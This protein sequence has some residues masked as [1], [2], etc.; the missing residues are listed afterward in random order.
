LRCVYLGKKRLER[1]T[2][3]Q[4]IAHP[5]IF[6]GR[7]FHQLMQQPDIVPPRRRF[8]DEERKAAF[9]LDTEIGAERP[10]ARDV[11]SGASLRL[12]WFDDAAYAAVIGHQ[13][14]Q[15]CGSGSRHPKHR[16]EIV[17]FVHRTM[18]ALL[19]AGMADHLTIPHG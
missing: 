14:R 1:R 17:E 15:Y 16:Y 3:N 4:D 13:S 18:S 6:Q 12:I 9:L 5:V 11:V 2:K 10:D 7:S 19:M 8:F